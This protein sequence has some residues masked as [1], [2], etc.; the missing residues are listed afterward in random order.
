MAFVGK[1]RGGDDPGQDGSVKG[2]EQI[3]DAE[4]ERAAWCAEHDSGRACQTSRDLFQGTV[5]VEGVFDPGP[6]RRCWA[7]SIMACLNASVSILAAA[8]LA[9][10]RYNSPRTI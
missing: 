2:K 4:F 3:A 8:N 6:S 1:F 7:T 5:R 9:Y 10:G